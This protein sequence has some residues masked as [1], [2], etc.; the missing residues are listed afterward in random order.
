MSNRDLWQNSYTIIT[1]CRS[2]CINN[3]YGIIIKG[4]KKKGGSRRPS[5]S[6]FFGYQVQNLISHIHI[7]ISDTINNA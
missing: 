1:V 7:T 4:V 2:F 5:F 6:L 3:Y